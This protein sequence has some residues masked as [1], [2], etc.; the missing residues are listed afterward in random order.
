MLPCRNFAAGVEQIAER[1]PN[2]PVC[3]FMGGMPRNV[4]V[5]AGRA[6]TKGERYVTLT[7][8]PFMPIPCVL[9]PKQKAR[10]FLYWARSARGMTR[11]DDGNAGK[12]VRAT[13]Q[14]VLVSVPSLA[15]HDERQPSVKG[16]NN[17]GVWCRAAY[18]AEDALD[19]QW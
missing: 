10:E 6:L 14:Q 7:A 2:T 13:K 11:A 4:A 16:S 3:L 19:Y 12:W 8:S 5:A 9:W 17:K 18:L 1:H 15:E